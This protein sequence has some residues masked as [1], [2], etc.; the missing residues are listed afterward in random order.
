MHDTTV[1]LS[2]TTHIRPPLPLQSNF[3]QIALGR[4]VPVDVAVTI[5]RWE[6]EVNVERRV[7]IGGLSL[8][9]S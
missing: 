6:G 1:T 9:L 4:R 2:L 7:L 5:P 3:V 8:I